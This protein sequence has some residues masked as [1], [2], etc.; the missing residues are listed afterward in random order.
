[1]WNDGKEPQVEFELK[2]VFNYIV[3][4]EILRYC[5]HCSKD[6][7]YYII[8]VKVNVI[9]NYLILFQFNSLTC[10]FVNSAVAC[11]MSGTGPSSQNLFSSAS[12]A[13]WVASVLIC[14]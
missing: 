10:M 1:M 2:F 7:S 6:L 8:L 9:I 12:Q 3:L 13:S 14:C 11:K 4:Y 5:I